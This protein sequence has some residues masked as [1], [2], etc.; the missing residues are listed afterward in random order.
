MKS[1]PVSH[2]TYSL[3]GQN[4]RFAL[5]VISPAFIIAGVA[6]YYPIFNSALMSLQ[7]VYFGSGKFEWV[8]LVNF[9]SVLR[10]GVF[11][12]SFTWTLLYGVLSSVLLFAVGMYF[13]VL[14]NRKMPGTNV[15]AAASHA[16]AAA[17]QVKDSR[18]YRTTDLPILPGGAAL[19]PK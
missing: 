18:K 14:L 1:V 11:I 8:G 9:R 19:N 5:L 16:R 15:I 12:K 17:A 4:I 2:Q 3:R 10:G 6:L 13:A 7:K